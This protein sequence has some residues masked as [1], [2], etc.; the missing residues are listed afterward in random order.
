M[1]EPQGAVGVVAR[2]GPHER[3][4]RVLNSEGFALATVDD[5]STNGT[6]GSREGMSAVVL[7][8]DGPLSDARAPIEA[9][10]R[11]HRGSGVVVVCESGERW[12]IRA[13]LASGAAGVVLQGAI[14]TCLGPCVR[15]VQVGL[16]CVPRARWQEVHPPPLSTRE[17]QIL[18]LVVMGCTNG[19]IAQRLVLA[20]STVKSHLSSAFAKLGVRSRNEAVD[21]IID[22]D[23]GL[24][25]GILG[26]APYDPQTVAVV[27]P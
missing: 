11:R 9:L 17:K 7:W 23:R 5:A 10:A 22:P 12:E 27:A 13:A 26:I 8:V 21:L 24:G 14:Q 25:I 18:G 1:T 19:Q 6:A 2:N 3:I 15:A 16:L 4:E 20:E